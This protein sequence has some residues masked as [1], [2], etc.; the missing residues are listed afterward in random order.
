LSIKKNGFKN[1]PIVSGELVKLLAVNTGIKTIE[2]LE[3]KVKDLQGKLGQA[4]A[5]AAAST[6]AATTSALNKANEN[7]TR[8]KAFEK[9]LEKVERA[10]EL[11]GDTSGSGSGQANAPFQQEEAL[12]T[13][14][15]DSE[16]KIKVKDPGAQSLLE[17]DSFTSARLEPSVFLEQDLDLLTKKNVDNSGR[18]VETGHI[19]LCDHSS[20]WLLAMEKDYCRLIH[21]AG[22]S[23]PG[24]LLKA[25]KEKNIDPHLVNIAVARLGLRCVRYLGTEP[26]PH[27]TGHGPSR[28]EP[29]A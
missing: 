23:S 2:V 1:D 5:N 29:R 11:S 17:P 15:E 21:V 4:K 7:K 19:E 27:K 12:P 18:R 20:S 8:L 9:R 28:A 26:P 25:M 6:K 13:R 24:N 3:T 14:K 22:H 10:E 16:D